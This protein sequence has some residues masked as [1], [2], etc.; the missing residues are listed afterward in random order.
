ME[1]AG[2]RLEPAKLVGEDQDL[3]AIVQAV[4]LEDFP[5][6][7]AA[8]VASVADQ[9]EAVGASKPFDSLGDARAS[10]EAEI[11]RQV[12]VGRGD[13]RERDCVWR[14]AKLLGQQSP[15][16]RWSKIPN[17]F[18]RFCSIIRWAD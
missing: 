15:A 11:E 14:E 4:L 2:I 18:A 17:S 3:K 5:Q 1:D 10:A 9:A 12:L 7:F 16:A 8:G 6:D 13:P